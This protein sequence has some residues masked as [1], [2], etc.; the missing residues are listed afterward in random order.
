MSWFQV[1]KPRRPHSYPAASRDETMTFR[2]NFNDF[3]ENCISLLNMQIKWISKPYV[4]CLGILEELYGC[5][6][7][8]L[9]TMNVPLSFWERTSKINSISVRQYEQLISCCLA[10]TM[11]KKKPGRTAN[12][13]QWAISKLKRKFHK[14]NVSLHKF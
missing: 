13:G 3:N 6:L 9:D 1:E 2:D 14:E 11:P 8:F 5:Q 12:L 4:C 7:I 10:N